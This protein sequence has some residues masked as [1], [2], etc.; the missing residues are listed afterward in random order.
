MPD[1]SNKVCLVTG[2][3]KGVGRGTALQLASY[4][5]TCYI[6]GRELATLET[7]QKEAEDRKSSGRIIPVE[8]DHRND[9]NT[10][11][12]F[13]TISVEQNG[14]LDLLVNNVFSAMQYWW[15]N[16]NVDFYEPGTSACG[17]INKVGMRNHHYSSALAAGLMIPRKRGLIVNVSPVGRKI[18]LLRLASGLRNALKDYVA[19]NNA[20][21]L[22]T[23]NVAFVFL[24]PSIVLTEKMTKFIE[25]DDDE[26]QALNEIRASCRQMLDCSESVEFQ[27]KC[28]AH[29]LADENMMKKSGQ[30][31]LTTDLAEEYNFEDVDGKSPLSEQSLKILTK[32]YGWNSLSSYIPSWLKL[33]KYFYDMMFCS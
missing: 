25:K 6:T 24:W 7:V 20:V 3:S 11:R 32:I 14:Q 12:V 16:F 26:D 1:L 2:A 5:A 15:D 21:N 23:N 4:G 30:I 31:L 10:R 18:Y 22:R 19:K 8:C 33:P 13:E 17:I 29:M 9:E 28:I 27:G